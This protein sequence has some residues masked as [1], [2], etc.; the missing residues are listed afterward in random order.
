MKKKDLFKQGNSVFWG[1]LTI[2][3]VFNYLGSLFVY[4]RVEMNLAVDVLVSMVVATMSC[5]GVLWKR[6]DD[7]EQRIKALEYHQ[8]KRK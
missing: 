7:L 1:T 8:S 2:M 5:F 6:V 4:N 3:I